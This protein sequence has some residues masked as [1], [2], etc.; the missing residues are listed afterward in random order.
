LRKLLKDIGFIHDN[1][2]DDENA[3]NLKLFRA[4]LCAGLYP[5]IARI[6]CVYNPTGRVPPL[7]HEIC[8]STNE[9]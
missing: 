2:F 7:R 9:Y 1:A 8:N 3:G 6:D 5:N 4:I